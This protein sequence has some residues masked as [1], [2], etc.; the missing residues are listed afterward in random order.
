M[1]AFRRLTESTYVRSALRVN[2]SITSCISSAVA[3]SAMPPID[4]FK[5]SAMEWN[6]ISRNSNSVKS[7]LPE[8]VML[9]DC[10]NKA[11]TS[12]SAALPTT[13]LSR[14]S[15]S[16]CCALDDTDVVSVATAAFS[17]LASAFSATVS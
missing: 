3:L 4:R 9:S 5:E 15:R 11:L 6:S 16:D 13:L 17:V 7:A 1:S 10:A 12:I 14:A 8:T 2:I